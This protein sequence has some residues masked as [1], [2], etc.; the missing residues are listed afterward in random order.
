MR[1]RGSARLG[2]FLQQDYEEKARERDY[3][4]DFSLRLGNFE[5]ALATEL[6]L[7]LE[8]VCAPPTNHAHAR[9]MGAPL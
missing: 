9:T 8:L 5:I 6:G 4:D 7:F 3:G 1:R 2:V